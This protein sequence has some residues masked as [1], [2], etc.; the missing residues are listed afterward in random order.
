[1]THQKL[2]YFVR[3]LTLSA[4]ALRTIR[5]RIEPSLVHAF[6]S[7]KSTWGGGDTG[8]SVLSAIPVLYGYKSYTMRTEDISLSCN[9]GCGYFLL[10]RTA[11]SRFSTL[12]HDE[13]ETVNRIPSAREEE[14]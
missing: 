2:F 13:L 11:K 4:D 1:M 8:W 14:E 7:E 9:A 3:D 10:T 12:W 6:H 5:T